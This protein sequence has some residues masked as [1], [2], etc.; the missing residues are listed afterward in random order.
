MRHEVQWVAPAPLWPEA[1]AGASDDVRRALRRPALLRFAGDDFMDEFMALIE[2]DAPRLGEYLARPE[3]WRTPTPTPLPVERGPEFVRK[4]SRLRLA[5]DRKVNQ[6]SGLTPAKVQASGATPGAIAAASVASAAGPLKLYQ[7]AHQRFYLVTACLVCRLPGLPDR[8][9]D[10][11]REERV[12]YVIRRLW[13]KPAPQGQPANPIREYAFV[14]TPKGNGWQETASAPESL[15]ANE[16][17]LPLFAVNFDDADRR[18]R[19]LYSGMIPVGRREAYMGAGTFTPA[20]NGTSAPNTTKRTERKI[21]FRMQVTEPWKNLLRTADDAHKTLLSITTTVPESPEEAAKLLAEASLLKKTSR[22]SAQVL[23][24]YILLDFAKYLR[25]YA[26]DV[27]AAVMFGGEPTLPA[28]TPLAKLYAA[29]NVEMKPSPALIGALQSDF[30]ASPPPVAPSM[31]DALKRIGKPDPQDPSRLYWEDR[32]DNVTSVYARVHGSGDPNWPDFLFALADLEFDAPLPPSVISGPTPGDESDLPVEPQLPNP[33]TP[34]DVIALAAKQSLIDKLVALVV[35]TL[36]ADSAEAVPPAPLASRPVLDT[37]EGTFVIRCVYERPSCGPLDPPL[38]SEPSA[39]FQLASFFDPEAPARPIRIALPIDTSAAGLRK[40]DK[41][42]AF[43]I[44]DQLCGQ[45]QR[46]KGI[47]FGDLVLSVLP[48]P[49][50][51]DLS[52]GAPE[53]GPCKDN[54]GASLGMICTL[55]IPIITICA[56]VLLFVIVLLLDLIFHW[57]PFFIMCFPLPGFKGKKG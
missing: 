3:T 44:S 42:T 33:P 29:L 41:N 25:Q 9:L 16:E 20:T 57:I 12:G 5:A 43:M 51:K 50:H 28:D 7:P 27:W 31:R 30:G 48:W 46:L 2:H 32:L 8:A 39:Q 4:I 1:A 26:P 38:M 18:R 40:F 37:R 55:S 14:V 15:V 54:S 45:M 34:P 35:R 56:L 36:P 17:L 49:F 6:L 22:E 53:V 47:T 13:Q 11:A 19:R 23:S 24:W 10:T 21:H 52:V